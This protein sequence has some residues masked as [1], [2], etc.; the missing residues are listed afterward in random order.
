MVSS[1]LFAGLRCFSTNKKNITSIHTI[2][3][4]NDGDVVVVT[5]GEDLSFIV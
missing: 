2:A 3:E 1:S 5:G 4:N